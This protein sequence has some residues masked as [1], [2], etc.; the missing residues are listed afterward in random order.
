MDIFLTFD[1]YN[2]NLTFL[3]A[4]AVDFLKVFKGI[5]GDGFLGYD[6]LMVCSTSISVGILV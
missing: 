3:A 4:F 5:I 1:F 2:H 6:L